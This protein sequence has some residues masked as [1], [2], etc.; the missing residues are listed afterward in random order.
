MLLTATTAWAETA[1]VSYIDADGNSQNVKVSLASE[2]VGFRPSCLR[3]DNLLRH[4]RTRL[5]AQR[6]VEDT[7]RGCRPDELR[8]SLA[9]LAICEEIIGEIAFGIPK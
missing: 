6:P 9:F 3:V 8:N 4:L 2:Q 1:N 7:N 5:A